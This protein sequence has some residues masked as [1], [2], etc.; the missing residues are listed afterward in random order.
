MNTA[1]CKRTNRR[2]NRCISATDSEWRAVSDMAS[3]AGMTISRFVLQR[4]LTPSISAADAER[5]SLPEAAEWNQ[6]R[7]VMI[8]MRIAE[9][10][11]ERR[12]DTDRLNLIRA[13]VEERIS[14]W[15]LGF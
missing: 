7:A 15:R 11:M 12:G 14:A 4:V 6:L 10:N 3:A 9:E 1:S 13:E 5:C 8:L 2:T